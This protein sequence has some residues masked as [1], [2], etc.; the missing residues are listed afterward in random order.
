MKVELFSFQKTALERL[1]SQCAS[2]ISSY[3]AE[4]PQVI[5]FTAPTG[6]GKTIIVSALIES[7]LFGDMW[8]SPRP[9]LCG[10]PIHPN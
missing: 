10:F 1:R 2:A 9:S 7:I 4:G 3:H 5:S 8:R 6:A